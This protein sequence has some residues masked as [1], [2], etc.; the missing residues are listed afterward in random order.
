MFFGE[1]HIWAEFLSN[2]DSLAFGARWAS[3]SRASVGPTLATSLDPGEGRAAEFMRRL[4]ARMAARLSSAPQSS[5][6]PL[7]KIILVKEPSGDPLDSGL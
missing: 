6:I 7:A 3:F 1:D 5:L 2:G 4:E